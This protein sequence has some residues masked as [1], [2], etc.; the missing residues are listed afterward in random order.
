MTSTYTPVP[1]DFGSQTNA[2]LEQYVWDNINS[3][4]DS[5]RQLHED[6]VRKWRRLARGERSGQK[7]NFPWPNA[8][9]LVI[10]VIG[11]C[12]DILKAAIM[13]S[14]WEV[15]PIFQTSVI[16]EWESGERAEEQ[17]EAIQNAMDLWAAERE[18]LDLYRVE[19]LWFGEA[20][21]F[22]SSFTKSAFEH[23][24]EV[25]KISLDGTSSS[26]DSD[27]K[28]LVR[29]HGPYPV[30]IPFE[31]MGYDPKA[32][33]LEDCTF[34]YHRLKLT[35]YDLMKRRYMG[36][37]DAK[38]VDKIL[39]QFDT[40]TTE[41]PQQERQA[42]EGIA[43]SSAPFNAEYYIYECWFPYFH[44]NKEYQIVY[45]YHF[46]TKTTLKRVYNFYPDNDNPFRM[47]RLGYDDDGLLGYGYAEMLEHYQEEI[48]TKHNQRNDAGTL[49]NT[50]IARVSRASKLD[51]IFSL[52]PGAIVP[53]EQNE[54]EIMQLGRA[55]ESS[56]PEE[57]LSLQ[58]AER[59]AGVDMSIT[60]SGS[61]VVN[62]RKGVYSAM[63]T[64]AVQQQS[65]RRSNLRT[66][67]MKYSHIALGRLILK[68]Y[69][70]FGIHNKGRVFGK[71]ERYLIAALSNVKLGK[72][73]FPVRASTASI[74]RE[75]EK[76][77][78]MLLVNVL[79]QHHMGVAQLLQ[80][81]TS[82]QVPPE[83]Q[84]YLIRT[85]EAADALMHTVLRNF[86]HDDTS[87]LLPKNDLVERFKAM[88]EFIAKQEEQN[89]IR[90]LID[91]EQST[92]STLPSGGN[93]GA[94]NMAEVSNQQGESTS[95]IPT[96]GMESVQPVSNG[97]GRTV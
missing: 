9:D 16:G 49:A 46:K 42:Q 21:D 7:K 27:E 58:L 33:T 55:A 29:R 90:S 20:I 72:L 17:R 12:R 92:G 2:E 31:D 66:T 62:P 43:E 23:L 64:F 95:P 51:S 10:Q 11:T 80:A 34:K 89:K 73:D 45:T 56:V 57:N 79:R 24:E 6:K 75:L 15:L 14:I 67:D 69:A 60:A 82:G 70:H 35:R 22:G 1:V 53:G 3:I 26:E 48:S 54:I 25:Q 50:S 91:G 36:I 5:C 74:N 96:S 71:N 52:Y 18:E 88:E 83:M 97:V 40:P 32:N 77:N 78:D 19:S 63:G 81:V 84:S 76:Q 61:G 93:G 68:L 86:G 85:M 65:N 8:S 87:R 28:I 37:Y 30:K 94:V 47:A 4:Q 13:A 38:A 39:G 59:R 41:G 44:N